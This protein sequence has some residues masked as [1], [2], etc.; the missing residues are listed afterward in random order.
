MK[1]PLLIATNNPGKLT[2]IEAILGNLPITLINP[3]DIGI[4]IEVEEDGQT[5]FEN[6]LKKAMTLHK[7][8]GLITLADDS[9]LEVEALNGAPGIHSK[10][11]SPIENA[12]D[13]DR[14][15][16]LIQM[17]ETYPQ[18]WSACFH[19]EIV[20]IDQNK[21]IIKSRGTCPGTIIPEEKGT[22]G[23]GYD[24]IFYIPEQSATMAELS[25]VTKNL[26]S[27][28]A[29]ALITLLPGIKQLFGL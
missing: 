5:Y 12:T 10:R 28:R 2:E 27:H 29:K 23:F 26:I 20:V 13:S 25:S 1:N 17:L 24:S 19:C 15:K 6:A 7:L 16:Y 11:Y 21:S 8:S 3:E 9:G 22:G 18:P 4:E 14:R